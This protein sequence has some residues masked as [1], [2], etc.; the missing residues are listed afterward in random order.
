M[1]TETTTAAPIAEV[2][3]GTP[4]QQAA[5]ELRANK[6]KIRQE[7]GEEEPQESPPVEAAAEP[8]KEDKPAES[9]PV[10]DDKTIDKLSKSWASLTKREGSLVARER[11]ASE[12]ESSV[13]QLEQKYQE[14]IAKLDAFQKDP[15]GFMNSNAGNDWYAKA[16]ERFYQSPDG[17][18]SADERVAA[19]EKQLQ[20]E[21]SNRDKHI[22]EAIKSW[23]E[24]SQKEQ[25][26]RTTVERY[27][28]VVDDI[29]DKDDRFELTRSHPNGKR[30]VKDLI[31]KWYQQHNEVLTQERAASM[32]ETELE[33]E[34]EQLSATKK[35]KSKIGA[36]ATPSQKA[37]T[38]PPKQERPT[39]DGPKTLTSELNR[40][41]TRWE[42]SSRDDVKEAAKLLRRLREQNRE[43]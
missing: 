41:P 42:A 5:R 38:Q 27:M 30:Y 6:S 10:Q 25:E 14:A 29:V 12:R 4:T 26:E 18:M 13:K 8:T 16:T 3:E 23:Q 11:A 24:K 1:S 2:S 21:L 22:Q 43:A 37:T 35:A 39:E 34:L 15:I 9:A 17:K 20:D 40:M 36:V 7:Q 33:K 32:I 31:E 19:L 28:S